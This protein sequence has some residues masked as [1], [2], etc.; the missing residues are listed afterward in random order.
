M[1]TFPTNEFYKVAFRK[2]IYTSLEQLQED[3]DR[4]VYEYNNE[5]THTGKHCYGK[6]PM[7]TFLASLNLAKEKMLNQQYEKKNGEDHLS[8]VGNKG[9]SDEIEARPDDESS[10]HDSLAGIE[11]DGNF[12]KAVNE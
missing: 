12:A 4:W 9:A 6:T 7:Q 3:L 8:A 2:K 11:E 5:R 1:E 10:V